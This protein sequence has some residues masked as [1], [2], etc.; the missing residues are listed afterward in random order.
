MELVYILTVLFCCLAGLQN[1]V[2]A[3]AA[4]RAGLDW[5]RLALKSAAFSAGAALALTH[6]L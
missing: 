2:K 3:V 5:R 1:V 4:Y 6:F